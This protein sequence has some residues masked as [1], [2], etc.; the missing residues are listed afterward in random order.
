MIKT[1]RVTLQNKRTS[2]VEWIQFASLHPCFDS[3]IFVFTVNFLLLQ[4]FKM[5]TL[6]DFEKGFN[7]CRFNRIETNASLWSFHSKSITHRARVSS[8]SI[9]LRD[10]IMTLG[11]FFR[12]RQQLDL[13]PKLRSSSSSI[14]V[15]LIETIESRWFP[16]VNIQHFLPILD[17]WSQSDEF[18]RHP[19]VILTLEHLLLWPFMTWR[20]EL[21]ITMISDFSLPPSSWWRFGPTV[22]LHSLS[23]E[24]GN[25]INTQQRVIFFVKETVS[26]Q[27]QM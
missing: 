12:H 1:W 17:F 20:D 26:W 21:E 15:P 6:L 8:Y 4:A 23:F 14:T 16:E 25:R 2:N 19:F 22:R 27:N 3:S 18:V 5:R 11:F 13:R 9:V 24:I 10:W 7:T